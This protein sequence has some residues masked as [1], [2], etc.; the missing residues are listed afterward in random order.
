MGVRPCPRTFAAS[1]LAALAPEDGSGEADSGRTNNP[2]RAEHSSRTV[3]NAGCVHS[4]LYCRRCGQLKTEAQHRF[5]REGGGWIADLDR[6][7]SSGPSERQ[8]CLS[9]CCFEYTQ[10]GAVLA[11]YPGSSPK[12][13]MSHRNIHQTY[14]AA[15]LVRR[16]RVHTWLYARHQYRQELSGGDGPARST[17]TDSTPRTPKALRTAEQLRDINTPES[18][19]PRD[20]AH[21]NAP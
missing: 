13:E 17:T 5:V 12:V 6:Q 3:C 10:P 21:C 4:A 9:S 15:A 16:Q 7:L 1:S 14:R 11:G 20:C 18:M 2:A 8:A 19:M